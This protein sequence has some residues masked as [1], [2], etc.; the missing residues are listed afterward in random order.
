M[1]VAN[2]FVYIPEMGRR[3]QGME[4]NNLKCLWTELPPGYRNFKY[5][6]ML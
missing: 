5:V 6:I 4:G 2:R 1:F 3:D